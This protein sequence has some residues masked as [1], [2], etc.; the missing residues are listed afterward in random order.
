MDS[1][2][3]SHGGRHLLFGLEFSHESVKDL[4]IVLGHP[5]SSSKTLLSFDRGH[6]YQFSDSL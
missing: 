4:V 3:N 5:D 6:P 1:F 2:D